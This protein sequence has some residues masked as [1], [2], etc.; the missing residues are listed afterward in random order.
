MIIFFCYNMDNM[1]KEQLIKILKVAIISTI[2]MLVAEA[3]FSIPAI[4]NWFGDII[5][6]SSGVWVWVIIWVIMFLQVTILNIPAYV[7]LSASISI[8]IETLSVVYI[9]VV[10]SAYMAGCLLAYWLGYKFGIKAVKWCAGSDEDYNKWSKFLNEKGKLWYF[11]T[12]LFPFFPDDLLCLVAGG[13]K[14]NFWWYTVINFVGRG[15]G[16][17]TM[18]FT[19]KFITNFANGFPIMLI[20]WAVAL[21]AEII[22][23][24][25]V[26]SKLNTKENL[27]NKNQTED[28]NQG[29]Q[30]T[31]EKN[32][33]VVEDKKE[34]KVNAKTYKN[35]T[36]TSN[37]NEKNKNDKNIK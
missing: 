16:L 4:T 19:L 13:V 35:K 14:F 18:L 7:I 32:E 34:T 9:A 12:V 20:V 8:G 28:K 22:I 23:Y 36:T 25:I 24:Y 1:K 37:N 10:L 15:I 31:L 30:T 29:T 5:K 11:L 27:L 6:N 3:I 33:K 21:I 17:V 2:I 26:K